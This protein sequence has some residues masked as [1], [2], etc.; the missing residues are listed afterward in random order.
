LAAFNPDN[1]IQYCRDVDRVHFG[2]AP[3]ISVVASAYGRN[4]AVA[5]L[6]IQINDLSEFAGCR[7]KLTTR[8]TTDT[9]ML[10][11]ETY[12]TYKLTEFMLFF[13]RFKRCRYGRFYG[14]VDPMIIMQS[15]TEFA[16]ERAQAID[17]HHDAA[18]EQRRRTADLEYDALRERYRRRVPNAFTRDAPITFLQ[19]RLMGFDGMTDAEL[20][21]AIAGIASGRRPIP[22]HVHEII[23]TIKS[24]FNINEQ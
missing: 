8:Q 2:K 6:E 9:A 10:I 16:G 23:K 12:P 5:W 7:E 24:T 11:L 17:R 15:L 19:Y 20:T 14:A 1:Q 22:Q 21:E 3:S 13:H 4:T 18:R